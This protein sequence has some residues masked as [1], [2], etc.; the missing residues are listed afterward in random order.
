MLGEERLGLM[1]PGFG[2]RANACST[3]RASTTAGSATALASGQM[4][5][6]RQPGP[7]DQCA[8]LRPG[9]LRTGAATRRYRHRGPGH[10][11]RLA[12]SPAELLD[13][14]DRDDEIPEPRRDVRRVGQARLADGVGA[15]ALAGSN[16]SSWASPSLE[17]SRRRSSSRY[18]TS[19]GLNAHV[20]GVRTPAPSESPERCAFGFA[21]LP[22]FRS[23][24]VGCTLVR[25]PGL[26]G[27][28]V[29]GRDCLVEPVHW[30]RLSASAMQIESVS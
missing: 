10:G 21:S 5:A 7:P 14:A 18:L 11:G 16:W 22:L 17:R 13:L 6:G 29:V 26:R 8:W 30:R 25:Q 12:R 20:A 4:P 23:P 27:I 2:Q 19:C 1:P 15:R 24:V 28:G 3:S 9:P